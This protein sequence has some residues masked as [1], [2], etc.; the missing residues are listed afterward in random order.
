MT[1]S[2]YISCMPTLHL[3]PLGLTNMWVCHHNMIAWYTNMQAYTALLFHSQKLRPHCPNNPCSVKISQHTASW[4]CHFHTSFSCPYLPSIISKL[5]QAAT[6]TSTIRRWKK[7]MHWSETL[8][9]LDRL[10]TGECVRSQLILCNKQ[11]CGRST[12]KSEKVIRDSVAESVLASPNP[13]QSFFI[14]GFKQTS[15]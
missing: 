8:K 5:K 9:V 3:N 7:M 14:G 11:I 2:R 1:N 12:H 15:S 13:M 4:F 10:A 6:N